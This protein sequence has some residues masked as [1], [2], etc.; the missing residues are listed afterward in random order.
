MNA[1]NENNSNQAQGLE[2]LVQKILRREIKNLC[3]SLDCMHFGK[4]EPSTGE[5]II[6]KAQKDSKDDDLLDDLLELALERGIKVS[7]VPRKFLPEGQS[8]VAS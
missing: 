5:I 4:I 1:L 8:F 7:V 2:H 3:V 6:S